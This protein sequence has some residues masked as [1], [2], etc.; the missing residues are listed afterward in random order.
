M[1][2]LILHRKRRIADSQGN[3]ADASSDATA[4]D[5]LA[6]ADSVTSADS[7]DSADSAT[8]SASSTFDE[9]KAAAA[10]IAENPEKPNPSFNHSAGSIVIGMILTLLGG[11]L[12]G[13]NATVSKILMMNYHVSPMQIACVRQF[14]TGI[15]FIIIAAIFTPKQLV[16]VF[17]AGRDWFMIVAT[18]MV[19]VLFA[20]ITY[21]M[22]IDWTNSGTATVLQ[23]LNLLFVLLYVCLR[24]R[25]T[26]TMRENVG[27]ILA[28]AG[29]ALMATGGNINSLSLPIMGLV[30]GLGDAFSTAA[31]AIM[32]MKLVAKW[33]SFVINGITF[34]IAGSILMPFVRPW[35]TLPPLDAFAISLFVFTVVGGTFGAYWLFLA[36]VMRVGSVRATLL[37]AS[38]PVLAAITGVIFAGA[39]FS[40]AD[41]VGFLLI[42][43]MM[44]LIR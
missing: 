33:G 39:V 30:W 40:W 10:A 37:G 15:L 38:E 19:C 4:S 12:W 5:A 24:N 16:K 14:A 43:I 29:T 1:A 2:M 6:S 20:Q 23:S 26:P 21:L 7:A 8:Q 44:T 32:P 41:F 35:A 31:L 17:G 42:F 3:S 11:A 18:G 36:G 28:F 13:T 9:S 27:V 22:A 34:I 25:R